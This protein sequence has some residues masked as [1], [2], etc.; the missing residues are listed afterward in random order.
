MFWPW[1][2]LGHV[3]LSL[4]QKHKLRV[5]NAV[6]NLHYGPDPILGIVY[7][8][9]W[10]SHE[11]RVAVLRNALESGLKEQRKR[12]N[13]SNVSEELVERTVKKKKNI[14]EIQARKEESHVHKRRKKR[15]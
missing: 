5:A 11:L 14:Q 2:L 3:H 7:L 9:S 1:S 12:K 8:D 4:C 13:K 6:N 15:K 10:Q